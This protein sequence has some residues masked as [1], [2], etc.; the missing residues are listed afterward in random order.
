MGRSR[1]AIIEYGAYG[2]ALKF[3]EIQREIDDENWTV[4]KQAYAELYKEGRTTYVNY[5]KFENFV[6]KLSKF[7]GK[8]V[9]T[10]FTEKEWNVYMTKYGYTG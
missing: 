8:D 6:A 5:E 9:K 2:A 3:I 4:Y 7:S 1:S 10:L